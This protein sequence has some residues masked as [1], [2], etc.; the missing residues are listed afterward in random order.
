MICVGVFWVLHVCHDLGDD[1]DEDTRENDDNS[2]DE[3]DTDENDSDEDG[4]DEDDDDDDSREQSKN[5]DVNDLV[6]G[7]IPG[8]VRK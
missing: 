7:N 2:S 5:L 3:R 1:S 8:T 6:K 4:T